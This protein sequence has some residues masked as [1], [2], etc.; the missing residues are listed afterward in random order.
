MMTRKVDGHRL[1]DGSPVFLFTLPFLLIAVLV[2]KRLWHRSLAPRCT[3]K[4]S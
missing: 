2:L 3:A 1:S 4:Y